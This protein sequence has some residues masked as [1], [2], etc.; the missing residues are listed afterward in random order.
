M[1][2]GLGVSLVSLNIQVIIL[3]HFHQVSDERPHEASGSICC[4]DLVIIPPLPEGGGGYTVLPLS[5][6]RYF[7][8]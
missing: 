2:T 7:S 4:G 8:Q 1:Y 5:V 6:P 3:Y